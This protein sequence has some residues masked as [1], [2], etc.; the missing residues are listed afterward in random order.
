MIYCRFLETDVPVAQLKYIKISISIGYF[1]NLFMQGKKNKT[2]YF[3][4]SYFPKT[5][6][7]LCFFKTRLFSL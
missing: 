6:E 1:I 4:S 2:K 7:E 3:S 5:R